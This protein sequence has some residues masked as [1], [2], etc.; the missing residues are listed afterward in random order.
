MFLF[1]KPTQDVLS[2]SSLHRF[3]PIPKVQDLAFLE[4]LTTIMAAW[5]LLA[6][7]GYWSHRQQL[8][9]SQEML[10]ASLRAPLQLLLLGFV[11]HWLFDIQSHWAQAGMIAVFCV[12]AGHNAA[13][14]H[15][16]FNH[17]WIAASVGLICA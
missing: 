8:G 7:V 14:Q 1:K 10:V 5:L 3:P 9:L 16:R 4:T 17:A 2:A 6:G 13:E 12:L 11:L 15:P